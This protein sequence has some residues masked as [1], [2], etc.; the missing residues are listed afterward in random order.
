MLFVFENI[1]QYPW[2][3]QSIALSPRGAMWLQLQW[4]GRT[5]G[6]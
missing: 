5:L 3:P 6:D 2:G 4:W 1:I